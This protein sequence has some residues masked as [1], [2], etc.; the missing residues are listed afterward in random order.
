MTYRADEDCIICGKN[1]S[2]DTCWHHLKTRGSGGTDDSWNMV[3][4]CFNHHTAYF[5]LKGLTFTANKFKKVHEFLINNG[6][7][8]D[9]NRSKWYRPV[10]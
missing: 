7:I 3:P 5:H 9:E 4:V 1:T 8:F 2:K 10:N 6:W